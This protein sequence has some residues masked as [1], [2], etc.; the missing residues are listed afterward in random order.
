MFM[1]ATLVEAEIV[2]T[3]RKDSAISWG[4]HAKHWSRCFMYTALNMYPIYS[5]WKTEKYFISRNATV[6]P[7]WQ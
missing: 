4:L 5:Y 2:I 1:V 7:S 6:A 3:V